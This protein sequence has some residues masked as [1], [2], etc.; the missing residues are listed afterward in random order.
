MKNLIISIKRLLK[1]R[2]YCHLSLLCAKVTQSFQA[3]EMQ[4][5]KISCFKSKVT[6]PDQKVKVGKLNHK[7][8]SG[9]K[10]VSQL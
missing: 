3:S 7:E 8:N 9:V 4:I 5:K 1:Q 10:F 2:L 6:H